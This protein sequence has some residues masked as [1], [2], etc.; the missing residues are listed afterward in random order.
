[1]VSLFQTWQ[2]FANYTLMTN[3]FVKLPKLV[4]Q[5]LHPAVENFLV[6]SNKLESQ[7]RS[8]V[9]T[10]SAFLD[11][12]QQLAGRADNT[13]GK[14]IAEYENYFLKFINCARIKQR[15]R[16]VSDCVTEQTKVCRDKSTNVCKVQKNPIFHFI[17]LFVLVP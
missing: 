11:T 3:S 10:F 15:C 9:L 14:K 1:M 12:F 5:N 13:R 7:I 8:T 17:Y 16:R 2:A 4:V 6:Q